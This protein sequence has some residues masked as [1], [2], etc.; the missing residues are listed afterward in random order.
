MLE[1]TT[2]LS[3]VAAIFSPLYR[4]PVQYNLKAL[5]LNHPILRLDRATNCN[6][7]SDGI[8]VAFF[9][10][11]LSTSLMQ[12]P[13]T[14]QL[15]RQKRPY[16]NHV[17]SN[18]DDGVELSSHRD[19]SG[20]LHTDTIELA[21]LACLIHYCGSFLQSLCGPIKAKRPSATT[22]KQRQLGVINED[23]ILARIPPARGLGRKPALGDCL[24]L[25]EVHPVVAT[26]PAS[27]HSQLGGGGSQNVVIEAH[28]NG[29][30]MGCS[31]ETQ[32]KISIKW[33]VKVLKW[34]NASLIFFRYISLCG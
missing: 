14:L 5:T 21:G 29:A 27:Q 34:R 25:Y 9:L 23:D 2:V 19:C 3:L 17:E 22:N 20:A 4:V 28:L 12:L 30:G 11:S 6:C 13:A 16:G 32:I 24:L 10:A 33:Q 18:V 15:L 1:Q 31:Q 7:I 26:T 8:S